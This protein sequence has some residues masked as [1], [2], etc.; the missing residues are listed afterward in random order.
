MSKHTAQPSAQHAGDIL[1]LRSSAQQRPLTPLNSPLRP[2]RN[3]FLESF[4]ALLGCRWDL[5]D[6][7]ASPA[8]LCRPSLWNRA[9][10]WSSEETGVGGWLII[11]RDT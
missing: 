5:G 7:E 1:I 8:R 9:A 11:G 10:M 2:P 4:A 6:K 3:A